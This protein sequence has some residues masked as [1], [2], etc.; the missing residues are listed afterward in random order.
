MVK[1]VLVTGAKFGIGL[2]IAEAFA[3]KKF[4]VVMVDID[5]NGVKASASKLKKHYGINVLALK[6]DVSK[7]AQ[8]KSVIDS[9]K[10][11]FGSLDVLVNNAGIYPFKAFAELTEKDWDMVLNVNL[12]GVFLM[13]NEASRILNKGGSIV[14]ISSI[15]S[16]I[17]YPMLSHY[18]AS[19]GGINSFTRAL[20]LELAPLKIRVNAVAPGAIETPGTKPI[21]NNDLIKQ[22]IAATPLKRMGKP[23]DIANA[24]LF[25]A[26]KNADYIT[27]HVLV[28]DGGTTIQ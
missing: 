5:E 20:A 1:T 6:C 14:S 22:T 10:R 24:V 3:K 28:V 19:K 17:G 7:H 4:N 26:S 21:M 13:S 2:G 18:C 11:K 9:V 12:K 27:G 16:I 23:E 25:L 8:V 15:A